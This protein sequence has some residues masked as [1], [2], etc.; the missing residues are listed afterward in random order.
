LDPDAGILELGLDS[1][2]IGRLGREIERRWGV[3]LEAAWLLSVSPSLRALAEKIGAETRREEAV[4]AA[5]TK[6]GDAGPAAEPGAALRQYA[7]Q[8]QTTNELFAAQ[9]AAL[10]DFLASADGRPAS[11]GPL[12]RGFVPRRSP[13]TAEQTRFIADLAAAHLSATQASRARSRSSPAL[14]AE[15]PALS[16]FPEL[17]EL[18]YPIVAERMAGGAFTDVD[19]NAYI[20]IAADFLGHNPPFVEEAIRRRLEKGFGPGPQCDITALAAQNISRL[21]GMERVAFRDSGLAAAMLALRLARAR[22][23]KNRVAI[24]SGAH[25]GLF[26]GLF[27]GILA[28]DERGRTRPVSPGVPP[29]MVDEVMLLDY[30]TDAALTRLEA[31]AGRLA[32]VL[33]EPAPGRPGRQAQTF[34]RRLRRFTGEKGICLIFDER[35]NGFR[36][37]PGGS[38]EHFGVRADLVLFGEAAGGIAPVGVVAG[39]KE[40]LDLIDGG[41]QG[42]EGHVSAGE[43]IVSGG[44]FCRHPLAMEAVAAVTHHLLREGPALCAAAAALTGE[45]ADELNLW[46]QDNEA[47][48]RLVHYG[49]RFVFESYGPF[50]AFAQPIELPLFHLLL[51]RR[52]IYTGERRACGLCVAHGRREAEKIAE[53]ARESVLALRA[54]GFPFRLPD[55]AP[56][57]FAPTTPAQERLFALFRRE[58][59]Q[60]AC[61]LSLAW[62]VAGPV[63]AERLE[64]ALGEIIGRHEALRTAFIQRDGRL[65]QK[66]VAEPVFF[67]EQ[68]GAEENA[69]LDAG[70][71]IEA[72]IRPFDLSAPPLLRAH[73]ARQPDGASLFMLDLPCIAADGASLGLLLDELDTLMRGASPGAVPVSFREA[74]ASGA[75]PEQAGDCAYWVEKLKD[76]PALELPCDFPAAAGSPQSGQ[77][78][79]EVDAETLARARTACKLYGVT[80]D[81]FLD[82]AYALLLSALTRNT[83]VCSGR[84]DSGRFSAPAERAVGL[85]VNT[86]PRIFVTDPELSLPEFFAGVRLAWSESLRHNRAPCE[87]LSAALGASPVATMFGYERADRRRLE[88]PGVTATPLAIPSAARGRGAIHD[89]S[90]DIV[91]MDGAL[92]CKLT[93]SG[94][95]RA[96]TVRSFGQVFVQL[97]RELAV[98]RD[99]ALKDLRLLPP[100]QL[101]ELRQEWLDASVPPARERDVVDGIRARCAAAPESVALV[102][103]H[104]NLRERISYAQ[105][106]QKSD[107]LARRLMRLGAGPDKVVGLLL[108]GRPAFV[109][110]ALGVMKAGAAFLPLSPDF[111]P[112]RLGSLLKDSAAVALVSRT[113]LRPLCAD[114]GF[115]GEILDVDRD[116]FTEMPAAGPAEQVPPRFS[117]LLKKNGD[118]PA[119]SDLACVI[120]ASGTTGQPR[121]VMLERHSLSNLCQW[122]IRHYA[123]GAEDR[124]SVFDAGIPEIFPMLMR[125]VELHILHEDVRRDPP[126]L[127]D[128]LRAHRITISCFPARLAESIDGASLPDLRLLLSGGEVIGL[129]RPRG[130][131]RH[132]HFHGAAEF[133]VISHAAGLD[134]TRPGAIGKAVDNTQSLILDDAGRLMPFGF[135]GELCLAGEQL[136]RGYLNRPE[137]SAAAFAAN[138]AAALAPGENGTDYARMY[139]TGDLC[140]RLPDGNYM[141][142]G[143]LD[144]QAKIGG[145]R[146]ARGLQQAEHAEISRQAMTHP[147]V[148]HAVAALRPDAGGRESL[149][150]YVAPAT[151]DADEAALETELH[152]ALSEIPPP[153]MRPAD[154]VFLP[155][156]PERA[157]G[158]VDFDAPPPPRTKTAVRELPQGEAEKTPAVFRQERLRAPPD[159]PELPAPPPPAA[160]AP[161]LTEADRAALRAACG[162]GVQRVFPATPMQE[163][164]LA[165]R[166]GAPYPLGQGSFAIAGA[167]DALAMAERLAAL[168]RRHQALRTVF[169]TRAA[170]PLQVVLREPAPAFACHDLSA[171]GEEE[172]SARLSAA[173]RQRREQGIDPQRGPLFH[174]DLYALG[175][176][177]HVLQICFHRAALDDWSMNLI[178]RELFDPAPPPPAGANAAPDFADYAAWL[179]AADIQGSRAWWRNYLDGAQPT[180]LARREPPEDGPCRRESPEDGSCRRKSPEDGSCRRESPEDNP[181]RRQSSVRAFDAGLARALGALSARVGV[182]LDSILQSAWGLLLARLRGQEEAVFGALLTGRGAPLRGVEN[183]VGML[184]QTVPVRIRCRDALTVSAFLLDTQ[185]NAAALEK[186]AVLPLAEILQGTPH[187]AALFD[188]LCVFE[189]PPEIAPPARLTPTPGESFRQ[190]P[191]PLTLVVNRAPPGARLAALLHYDE[192]HF[193]AAFAAELLER[194]ESVLAQLAR[195]LDMMPVGEISI[196]RADEENA[197]PRAGPDN[198]QP[199]GADVG[200]ASVP[201]PSNVAARGIGETKSP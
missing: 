129:D 176:E 201:V 185:D 68:T 89:L 120:H 133:T 29:G 195:A 30:G 24:F 26:D 21:T 188:H 19:G 187:G 14:A 32:A 156:L 91:E 117:F 12:A 105:L 178:L 56:V 80:L 124:A 97:V 61:H 9:L 67:L 150:L 112:E 151:P 141:F 94:A 8:L 88:W 104:G 115:A 184:A 23:G 28:V 163:D 13:L 44:A 96:E 92:H 65:W 48:L 107:A 43:A 198:P 41:F 140:R 75:G 196:P 161:D 192:N 74:M 108:P 55:G 126:R 70:E 66:I 59:G 77:E 173:L 189:N 86:V 127:R 197:A 153:R 122:F 121:S 131:Y 2:T 51:R 18:A 45:L 130:A 166:P 83:R 99:A 47:P 177:K 128:Y 25:H 40:Y 137:Q 175:V 165:R 98:R 37:A 106:E 49:A 186:H 113:E 90:L 174:I 34:L 102:L 171:L 179:E 119:A 81:M 118:A 199:P 169:F 31:E 200:E 194:L 20:D 111:P 157:G 84:T 162:D 167:L 181:C 62:K 58:H 50:S 110:A 193:P 116:A 11:A 78:W 152:A 72:F 170:R 183:I 76:F 143:R 5:G 191:W 69:P 53:A 149:C 103:E 15:K 155:S 144:D 160:G 27:D 93:H 36:A 142:M 10:S 101:D 148:S 87:A 100:A 52:G 71:R 132:D 164:L 180:L 136:A 182:T 134:G 82:G 147:R 6:T 54:G 95:F 146:H 114:A 109:I 190:T 139:R 123:P 145:Q 64:I 35:D 135:P 46:F 38:Q 33:V 3:R 85:F 57:L 168:T 154:Y 172:Q 159:E 16:R 39:K 138:P 17:K 60:D 158:K 22:S 63:D 1:L 7:A 4:P 73:L 79:I 125:G 42:E